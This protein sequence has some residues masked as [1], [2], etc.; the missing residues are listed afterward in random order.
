MKKVLITAFEPFDVWSANSSWLTLVELTKELPDTMD[1]TTRLY[2][3]D[4]AQVEQRLEAD[5]ETEFDIALHLGQASGAT[6]FRLESIALNIAAENSTGPFRKL[7]DD[8]PAAIES[9]LP[10]DRF[11]ATLRSAGIPASQS[12]HAGTY[13]C[14]AIFY[15]SSHIATRNSMRTRCG[16]IHLPLT[17]TQTA[18]HRAE[19]LPSMPADFMAGGL[20]LVLEEIAGAGR[21]GL[22]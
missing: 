15:L 11:A 1:I 12:F 5:L 21:G 3:V 14:N 10:M 19:A 7:V 2:P 13:L 4:F 17:P 20:R 18:N 16:F 8:G 9:G 6:E 22:I